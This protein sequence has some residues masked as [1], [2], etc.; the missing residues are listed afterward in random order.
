VRSTVD[1]LAIT[2]WTVERR[3]RL[4]LKLFFNLTGQ[5]LAVANKPF[6]GFDTYENQ[7]ADQQ[8][9]GKL[10]Q[11]QRRG[12]KNFLQERQV[13]HAQLQCQ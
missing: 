4:L 13:D 5:R 7:Q 6:L 8:A 3:S 12:F 1:L 9:D 2:L 11:R 10:R